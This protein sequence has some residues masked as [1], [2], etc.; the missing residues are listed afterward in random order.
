[1]KEVT[2]IQP[3]NNGMRNTPLSIKEKVA[4]L[5][6][7][8]IC[9]IREQPISRD[10]WLVDLSIPQE[11]MPI[12]NKSACYKSEEFGYYKEVTVKMSNA[13]YEQAFKLFSDLEN[14]NPSEFY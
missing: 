14:T 9:E 3:I 13:F 5:A 8:L 7:F 2:Y 4:K 6:H 12:I 1:M 11:K 10:Y